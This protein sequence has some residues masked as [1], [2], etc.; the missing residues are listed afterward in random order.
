METWEK[1]KTAFVNENKE[2][3][4]WLPYARATAL[5]VFDALAAA[6]CDVTVVSAVT[7]HCYGTTI[8]LNMLDPALPADELNAKLEA[9]R[10]IVTTITRL[11]C[12]PGRKERESAWD[13]SSAL[14]VTWR[15]E[16]QNEARYNSDEVRHAYAESVQVARYMPPTCRFITKTEDVP[17]SEAYTRTFTAIECGPE[18]A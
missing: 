15:R 16:T 17:A 1:A 7:S 8:H 14:Q 10:K 9:Q 13:A 12:M 18:D 2:N 5:R 4:R 6:E 3:D 11:M